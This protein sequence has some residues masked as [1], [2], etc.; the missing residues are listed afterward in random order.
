MGHTVVASGAV[1]WVGDAYLTIS[2]QRFTREYITLQKLKTLVLSFHWS[3]GVKSIRLLCLLSNQISTTV[4]NKIH[5]TQKRLTNCVY[6]SASETVGEE[7][8]YINCKREREICVC[9]KQH[10][11]THSST[12]GHFVEIRPVE[13]TKFTH[14]NCDMHVCERKLATILG[15]PLSVSILASR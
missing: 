11:P 5:C 1:S 3:F 12:L 4:P 2:W 9:L 8:A 7:I 6:S 13:E 15:G 10:L 14:P